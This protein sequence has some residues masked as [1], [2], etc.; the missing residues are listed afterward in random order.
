MID[1]AGTPESEWRRWLARKPPRPLDVVGL[2]DRVGRL[3]VIAPHPDDEVIACGALIAHALAQGQP[4]AIVGVTDGEASHDESGGWRG[5]GS[6][7]EDG[8]RAGLASTRRA[9]SDAGI[10]CLAGVSV[11]DSTVA[12]AAATSP[13]AVHRLRFRDGRVGEDVPA[14]TRALAGLL[15]PD[16]LVVTTWRRD[17]HPDHEAA[18]E[19]GAAACH[20]VGATLL[21][22]P[23]W[24]WHWAVPDDPRI[25][26]GR[27]RRI[28]LPAETVDL[29]VAAIR[30]HGTQLEARG[31]DWG[32]VL[33]PA[34]LARLQRPEEYVF[35]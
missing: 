17:G 3:V 33:T 6:H 12:D 13:I 23:V 2:L 8:A 18:G 30:A 21:E 16:D 34:L 27:L 22:S 24:M 32:P 29:K 19:A 4:V 14:L 28:A 10:A 7:G 9:E 5:N 25:P 26:W 20:A 31:A 1:G 11:D 15:R 35:V